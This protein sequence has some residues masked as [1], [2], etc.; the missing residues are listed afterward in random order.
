MNL[1]GDERG[2]I[3]NCE[4]RTRAWCPVL[5]DFIDLGWWLLIIP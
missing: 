5:P 3:R 2:L 1:N 4:F